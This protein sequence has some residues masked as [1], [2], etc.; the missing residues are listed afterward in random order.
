MVHPLGELPIAAPQKKLVVE[1]RMLI[2]HGVLVHEKHIRSFGLIQKKS[3]MN[4]TS[5]S[6]TVDGTKNPQTHREPAQH[7]KRCN[8]DILCPDRAV[9]MPSLGMPNQIALFRG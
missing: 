2:F 3:G 9:F 4:T 8:D 6:L 5:A 7:D 1:V